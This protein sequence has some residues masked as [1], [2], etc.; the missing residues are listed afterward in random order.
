MEGCAKLVLTHGWSSVGTH[1][2]VKAGLK[3]ATVR[4]GLTD[5]GRQVFYKVMNP[6]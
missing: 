4:R 3:G 2:P 1:Y 5:R 6:T